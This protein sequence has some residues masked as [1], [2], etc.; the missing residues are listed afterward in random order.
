MGSGRV[1]TRAGVLLDLL[2]EEIGGDRTD[3]PKG[4]SGFN[5]QTDSSGSFGAPDRPDPIIFRASQRF[6]PTRWRTGPGRGRVSMYCNVEMI[7][8][9]VLAQYFVTMHFPCSTDN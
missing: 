9:P 1:A 2:D 3:L 4:R 6:G 5:H 7:Y 8:E